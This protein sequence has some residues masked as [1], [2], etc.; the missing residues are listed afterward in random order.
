MNVAYALFFTTYR[1]VNCDHAVIYLINC[2][3][4]NLGQEFKKNPKL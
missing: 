1:Q 4:R 2:D 3:L